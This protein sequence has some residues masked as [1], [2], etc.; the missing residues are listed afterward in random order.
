MGVKWPKRVATNDFY[1]KQAD[2][3]KRK[4]KME[5]K[6]NKI[7]GRF[8]GRGHREIVQGEDENK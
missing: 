4:E 2:S 6:K 3:L 8:N 1:R 5:R 7:E